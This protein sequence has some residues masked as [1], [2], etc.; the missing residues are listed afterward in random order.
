MPSGFVT[1]HRPGQ[2]ACVKC[3]LAQQ[4]GTLRPVTEMLATPG[5][6]WKSRTR[7]N[8]DAPQGKDSMQSAEEE[9]P[10]HRKH[11]ESAQRAPPP[12]STYGLERGNLEGVS[13]RPVRKIVLAGLAV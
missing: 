12:E 5:H 6:S 9:A 7:R 1:R 11:P 4:L 3:L 10:T 8:P 2:D 13:S